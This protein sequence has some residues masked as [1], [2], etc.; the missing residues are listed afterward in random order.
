MGGHNEI[1]SRIEPT[2]KS[3]LLRGFSF[4]EFNGDLDRGRFIIDKMRVRWEHEFG[5]K[6]GGG[7]DILEID[8][9]R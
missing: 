8:R 1:P 2:H 9:F 4:L 3:Y 6:D 5:G 7:G